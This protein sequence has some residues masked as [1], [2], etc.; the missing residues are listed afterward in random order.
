MPLVHLTGPSW[1]KNEIDS[2][3]TYQKFLITFFSVFSAN[4]HSIDIPMSLILVFVCDSDM[5][6]GNP[7]ILN[8]I[9]NCAELRNWKQSEAAQQI[10][11]LVG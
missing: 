10:E 1:R 4:L 9:P 11:Y 8:E 6:V 2:T 7:Q 5:R 3:G